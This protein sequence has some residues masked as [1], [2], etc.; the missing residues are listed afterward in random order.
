MR[1]SSVRGEP[2]SVFIADLLSLAADKEDVRAGK[3]VL[4]AKVCDSHEMLPV[5][6]EQCVRLLVVI[7]DGLMSKDKSVVAVKHRRSFDSTS[8]ADLE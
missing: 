5:L 1:G 8:A 6:L 7:E 3:L 4:D 2:E